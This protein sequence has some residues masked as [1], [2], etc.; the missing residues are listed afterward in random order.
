MKIRCQYCNAYIDD[1][2]TI[3]PTCGAPNPGVVRTVSTQPLTIEQLQSWY[4]EHHL[5]PYEVTRFFIGVDCREARAFGIYR[6][7]SNFVVYKN[8]SDGSRAIRYKGTDEAYAVNEIFQRLKQEIIEQK[9]VQLT[10]ASDR[11]RSTS[12]RMWSESGHM[13]NVYET[14]PVFRQVSNGVS[15]VVKVRIITLIIMICLALL[16]IFLQMPKNPLRGG[17]YVY[18]DRTYFDYQTGSFTQGFRNTWFTATEDDWKKTPAFGDDQVPY[19]LQTWKKA[20]QY[21]KGETWTPDYSAVDFYK[22]TG[23]EDYEH[24]YDSKKGYY[25][26]DDDCYYHDS[27]YID[28]EWYRYD[29]AEESWEKIYD[30]D[31][32]DALTHISTLDDFWF[33]PEWDES[34][35][36]TDFQDQHSSY[37]H[38]YGSTW[39]NYDSYDYDWGSSDT[40]D[41]YDS[42][43][44]DWGSSDTWDSGT[45]DWDSDW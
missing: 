23:F 41:N 19:E 13:R 7:G 27:S 16:A 43:D 21:Y 25:R 20:E 31:R 4:A 5:P 11:M 24:R 6:E 37:N 3:C 34:T 33:V 22:S 9:A 10:K 40:W 30:E 17:Y 1:T 45:T 2:N 29:Q 26:Y 35:Q 36:F 42:Y 39:N 12:D 14:P 18:N 38:E 28:S 32:P 44:Y 15:S 8:K